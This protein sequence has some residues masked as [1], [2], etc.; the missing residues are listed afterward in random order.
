MSRPS[1][2]RDQRA[3]EA[4][5]AVRVALS[6]WAARHA[7]RRLPLGTRRLPRCCP[8]PLLVSPARPRSLRAPLSAP[9]VARR[10][11]R[12]AVVPLDGRLPR[13]PSRVRD[14]V[15]P[16]RRRPAGRGAPHRFPPRA[17]P[18][19]R[20][21]PRVGRAAA[22]AL[23]G[24]GGLH[25]GPPRPRG[26]ATAPTARAGAVTAD[27]GGL[28]L[29]AEKLSAANGSGSA[30]QVADGPH[31]DLE[32]EDLVHLAAVCRD[33]SA[34]PGAPPGPARPASWKRVGTQ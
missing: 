20:A 6:G 14:R 17:P 19:A 27:G 15:L 12:C 21:P 34:G 10:R 11:G 8:P 33:A 7:L 13:S 23:S 1:S 26:D 31:L 9:G 16:P 3:D 24:A 25:R 32:A 4:R 28:S 5:G 2:R 22:A 29:G 30:S 18:R